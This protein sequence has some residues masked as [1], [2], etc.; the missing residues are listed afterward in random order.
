MRVAGTA[1]R[2]VAKMAAI[3]AACLS[4]GTLMAQLRPDYVAQSSIVPNGLYSVTGGEA[5]NEVNGSLSYRLPLVSMPAGRNGSPLEISA[6]YNSNIFDVT[7]ATWMSP[8]STNVQIYKL[9]QNLLGGWRLGYTYSI[10]HEWRPVEY[11]VC[12]GTGNKDTYQR[13]KTR[14][15]LPDGSY[16]TLHPSDA[17]PDDTTGD[18]YYPMTFYGTWVF[19]ACYSRPLAG[20]TRTYYTA[21]GSYIRVEVDADNSEDAK[22]T[23]RIYLPDGRTVRMFNDPQNLGR[24]TTRLYERNGNY[25]EMWS[26]ANSGENPKDYIRDAWGRQIMIE[27]APSQTI[28]SYPGQNGTTGGAYQVRVNWTSFSVAAQYPCG[29]DGGDVLCIADVNGVWPQADPPGV[30][31]ISSVEFPDPGVYSGDVLVDGGQKTVVKFTYETAGGLNFG[32]PLKTVET[33]CPGVNLPDRA[34]LSARTSYEYLYTNHG[35]SFSGYASPTPSAAR[36][37]GVLTQNPMF[38]KTVTY[39]DGGGKPAEMWSYSFGDTISSVTGPDGG[40][41]VNYFSFPTYGASGLVYKSVEP[42]GAIV[43][44]KWEQNLPPIVTATYQDNGNAYVSKQSRVVPASGGSKASSRQ[45]VYD[46]NGNVVRVDESADW[47]AA[48]TSAEAITMGTITRSTLNEYYVAT[49][50]AS[51][52]ASLA[53]ANGHWHASAPRHDLVKSTTVSGGGAVLSHATFAFDQFGNLTE[54]RQWDSTLGVYAQTLSDTNSVKVSRGYSTL[55]GDG[56]GGDLLWQD[57]ARSVRT[58]YSYGGAHPYATQVAGSSGGTNPWTWTRTLAYDANTGLLLSETDFDNGA[59]TSFRHDRLGRLVRTTEAGLRTSSVAYDD[60]NRTIR[61]TSPVDGSRSVE[62]VAS[63]DWLGRVVRTRE[64]KDDGTQPGGDRVSGGIQVVTA[65]RYPAGTPT[66]NSYEIVSNPRVT[67]TESSKGWRRRKLDNAGRVV[68]VAEYDSQEAPAPEGTATTPVATSIYAYDGDK[69]RET[70]A[71]GKIKDRYVDAL[72]RLVKVVED[73]SGLSLLTRY[74]YDGLDRLLK[75]CQSE[76]EATPVDTCASGRKRS[77]TYSSLGRLLTAD[78]P[79]TGPAAIS[80]TYDQNGNVLSKTDGQRTVTMTYDARNRLAKKS[81]SDGGKTP[82]V[83]YCYDGVANNNTAPARDCTGAPQG[84]GVNLYGRLTMV[85]SSVSTTK[86]EGYDTLGRVTAHRQVTNGQEY[87]FSY[88]YNLANGLVTETYPSG[89][90]ATTSYLANGRVAGVAGYAGSSPAAA[91]SYEPFGGMAQVALANGLTEGRTYNSGLRLKTLNVAKSGGCQAVLALGNTY[92]ANG[93][94]TEQQIGRDCGAFEVKQDA[95]AWGYDGANRL[96]GWKEWK[97]AEP[98]LSNWYR[99]YNYDR[100]GNGWVPDPVGVPATSFTP[101]SEAWFN[102]RNRLVPPGLASSYDGAGN[103]TMI[104]SVT[105]DYDGENKLKTY[106]GAMGYGYDGEGRRVTKTV[107]AQTT[108]MVYDALGRLAA[109][110]GGTTSV[111]GRQYVTADALGS[112][113]LVS[114][115]DGGTLSCSDYVPFGEE[116]GVA[117]G[118]RPACYGG[119]GGVKVKFTGKERDAETA[120]SGMGDGLDYFGA[121][122][123]AAVMGRFTSA[124]PDNFDARLGQ[125]QSWNMYAYTWNNPLKYRDD[126]GRAVNVVLAGIGTGVGFVTNF[127]GSAISQQIST[128]HVDWW[129]ATKVGG[130]GAATGSLAGLT[131]GASLVAQGASAIAI[132]TLSN[133]AN[134]IGSRAVSGDDAFNM[135]SVEADAELGVVTSAG[136]ALLTGLGTAIG[137]GAQPKLPNPLGTVQKQLRRMALLKAWNQQRDNLSTRFS[138]AG[139]VIGS[140]VTNTGA[141]IYSA[142]QAHQNDLALMWLL[143]SSNAAKRKPLKACV[144]TVDSASGSRSKVCE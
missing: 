79:E 32:G 33:L 88:S 39:T 30:Y 93:N 50:A 104:G 86:Y 18:G 89:R 72:G 71:S 1:G 70:D 21:D 142:Y 118:S 25:M 15:V 82:E 99:T 8:A 80:Y 83:T 12:Q 120:N 2:R 119:N 56:G 92:A 106:A 100:Y 81:Y 98:G 132:G 141:S 117:V 97:T 4:G 58:T 74:S 143:Q 44:R 43:Y 126:D 122:Y 107:G 91:I 45:T 20:G 35:R 60:L 63:Y 108:V 78:N 42:S 10:E 66:G 16:H 61:K 112:T 133:V 125:P 65:Y 17:S 40:V 128:G 24:R 6:V 137:A 34:C 53:D 121:R 64:T 7:P 144:E 37:I 26:T 46:K 109:E 102:E 124:D 96:L 138:A 41:T 76:P 115:A 27:R 59:T 14:L 140:L 68:E 87:A 129:T 101:R 19:P 95:G 123:Y 49:G 48:P 9:K 84:T 28:I 111:S 31:G 103:L 110:Y 55:S 36:M 73:P 139:A 94:L 47:L 69:T 85:K 75:V 52:A 22:R 134:G 136:G 105:M 130:V 54:S 62:S 131:F 38:A 116:I 3:V 114:N 135:S 77:F 23:V 90:V 11:T 67:G 51:T 13:A 57:D 29:W 113:R 5:V 127:A